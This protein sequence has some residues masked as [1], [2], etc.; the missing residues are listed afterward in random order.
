MFRQPDKARVWSNSVQ[1]S[2]VA[3]SATR[4]LER[5]HV[6][7]RPL[8]HRGWDGSALRPKCQ[9]CRADCGSSRSTDPF[10]I[11][12][13]GDAI[14]RSNY[15]FQILAGKALLLHAEADRVDRIWRIHRIMLGLIHL[16]QRCQYIESVALWR[17]AL[18][19]PQA[20]DFG[21][22]RFMIRFRADRLQVSCHASP[23]SRRLC[24]R[25]T[26]R[27]NVL[28]FAMAPYLRFVAFTPIRAAQG[29]TFANGGFRAG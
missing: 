20:L 22:R 11:E 15:W 25:P 4:I 1:S 29:G 6:S 23:S 27:E 3:V 18:G 2:S 16:N 19:A 7:L 12:H 21:E 14:A 8:P 9:A 17:A 10:A 26:P 28:T 5:S 13:L 24:H